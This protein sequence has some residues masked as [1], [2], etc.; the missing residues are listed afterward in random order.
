VDT[1]NWSANAGGLG[2]LLSGIRTIDPA[3]SA[4]AHEAA[5]LFESTRQEIAYY[6]PLLARA[7]Q[8]CASLV[9]PLAAR[10]SGRR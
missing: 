3:L 8:R 7:L 4:P 9:H 1:L 6:F 10:Y 2:A 5:R